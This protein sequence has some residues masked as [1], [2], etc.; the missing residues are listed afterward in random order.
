MEETE[1]KEIMRDLR[2]LAFK[3]NILVEFL[4]NETEIK[5]VINAV[6]SD[7][8]LPKNTVFLFISDEYRQI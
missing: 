7:K 3:K 1:N 5:V 4:K 6:D 2:G 8:S